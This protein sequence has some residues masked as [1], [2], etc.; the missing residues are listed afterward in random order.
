MRKEQKVVYRC[1]RII[2]RKKKRKTLWAHITTWRNLRNI[3]SVKKKA[4]TKGHVVCDSII[5]NLQNWQIS[6]QFSCSVMSNSL[7]PRG[8]QHA[9]LPC[10]SPTS[11][12]CSNSCPSSQWCHLT[13][14]SSLVP[15]PS[16][17]Q[18]FPASRSFPMS[19]FSSSGQSI[20]ASASASALPMNS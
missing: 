9:R 1:N 4:N 14:S 11:R 20:G 17:L 13:I 16:C 5:W 3:T 8:L 7:K 19:Q 15:F 18:S 2:T 6:V 12:A 10:P